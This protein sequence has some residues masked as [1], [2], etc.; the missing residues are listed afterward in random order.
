MQL[1]NNDGDE[2]NDNN[3]NDEEDEEDEDEFGFEELD[4][5]V[6]VAANNN[7]SQVLLR[8]KSGLKRSHELDSIRFSMYNIQSK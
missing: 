8:H 2:D 4:A 1:D 6:T 3:H 7:S 5:Q